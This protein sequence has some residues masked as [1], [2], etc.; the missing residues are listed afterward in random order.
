[1]KKIH[2]FAVALGLLAALAFAWSIQAE[3]AGGGS[4][5]VTFLSGKGFK[6]KAKDGPWAAIKQG[7]SISA[8]H[9][10]KADAGSKIELTLPDNSKLRIAPNSVLFLS[11]ARLNKGAR[12]YDAQVASGKVYTKATPS[13][14]K[15][16]KFI[17]RSGGAVAGIR[18][19]AF[20]TILMPDGATQ[21]KCF[22]G[23]VWVASWGDYVQRMMSEE[24]RGPGGSLE[25][26]EVPGPGVVSEQEW[27]RI[28]G[29][30]MTISIGSDGKIS[31]PSAISQSDISDWE[32]WNR[33]RDAM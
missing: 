33:K 18:G 14:N 2:Y 5:K 31:D 26:H 25:A 20:D 9:Y 29:A 12:Q 32:D 27:V 6:S 22:E 1:M 13:K 28:V 3:P 19:T 10:V 7:N 4:A 15:N 24:P 23:K 21:V 17:V 11:S 8:G 16:D 30:M